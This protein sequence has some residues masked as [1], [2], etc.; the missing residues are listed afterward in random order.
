MRSVMNINTLQAVPT[1]TNDEGETQN[2]FWQR[3]FESRHA[4]NDS[5]V[6]IFAFTE[7]K[8]VTFT[9]NTH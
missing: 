3:Y 1:V 4:D 2:D 6:F 7:L 8:G 5:C 9:T